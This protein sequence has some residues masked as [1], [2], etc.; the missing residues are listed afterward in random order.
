MAKAYVYYH[1]T[2]NEQIRSILARGLRKGTFVTPQRSVAEIFA[3][4]RAAHNHGIPT[5]IAVRLKKPL[6]LWMDRY[7]RLEARLL[8]DEKNVTIED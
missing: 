2:T 3:R 5:I 7:G 4:S 1:G 8:C 6:I